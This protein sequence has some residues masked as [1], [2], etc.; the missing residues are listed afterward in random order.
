MYSSRLGFVKEFRSVLLISVFTPFVA[1]AG[2]LSNSDQS[3][4]T[5][6]V[7]NAGSVANPENASTIFL[8]PPE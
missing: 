3:A 1:S 6:A 8:T 5:S 7:S 4:S 2:G